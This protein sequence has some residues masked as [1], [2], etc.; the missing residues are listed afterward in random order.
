MKSWTSRR[1]AI[2]S[3]DWR[4][5]RVGAVT[6]AEVPAAPA[7]TGLV[8]TTPRVIGGGQRHHLGW[9]APA[10][11]QRRHGLHRRSRVRE[12]QCEALTKVVLARLAVAREGEPILR[13]ATMAQVP[14]LATH[15]LRG[16]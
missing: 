10:L 11:Q 13:A 9:R 5:R 12:E 7:G 6:E 15:A 2:G 1:T 14:D 4:A 8:G 3:G 16:Q